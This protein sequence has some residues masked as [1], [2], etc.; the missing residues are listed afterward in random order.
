MTAVPSSPGQ[1]KRCSAT[2]CGPRARTTV[3][4][5]PADAALRRIPWAKALW[6]GGWYRSSA[7]CEWVLQ[8]AH[9]V[10]KRTAYHAGKASGQA[11]R[12]PGPT[13]VCRA[14]QCVAKRRV[15]S[16]GGRP[17]LQLRRLSIWRQGERAQADRGTACASR[18]SKQEGRQQEREA[19]QHPWLHVIAVLA[20]TAESTTRRAVCTISS[21]CN[22][23]WCA[24]GVPRRARI[25]IACRPGCPGSIPSTGMQPAPEMSEGRAQLDVVH[26]GGW[27]ATG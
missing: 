11:A 20:R 14:A 22:N 26:T 16:R 24:M 8:H 6:W 1:R 25:C 27:D 18:R 4:K 5:G 23:P 9:L 15:A 3:R 10:P 12:T 2:R 19:S 17:K 21:N 7:D 13:R